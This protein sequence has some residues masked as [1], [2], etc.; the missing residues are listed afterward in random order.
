MYVKERFHF[1]RALNNVLATEFAV[2]ILE[3]ILLQRGEQTR[4]PITQVQKMAT[5]GKN[6]V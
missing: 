3:H 2:L 6:G 5:A 4:K 1:A